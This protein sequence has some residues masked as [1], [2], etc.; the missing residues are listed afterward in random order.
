VSLAEYFE[1]KCLKKLEENTQLLLVKLSDPL[2]FIKTSVSGSL[3]TAAKG[4]IGPL[5]TLGLDYLK[6]HSDEIALG[7]L[8]A[9]G[10]LNKVKGALDLALNLT[11]TLLALH[12]D[13]VFLFM[14]KVA[15]S[16]VK[17]LAAKRALLAEIN[18]L[19]L[20]LLS[21]MA[22]YNEGDPAFEAYLKQLR[23]GLLHVA[24]AEVSVNNVRATLRAR[25]QFLAGQWKTVKD[26][27]HLADT[28]IRPLKDN[29][30][31]QATAKGLATNLGLEKLDEL[32]ALST[33]LSK[34]KT[35]KPDQAQ[36]I[37]N[38]LSIP[39]LSNQLLLKVRDYMSHTETANTLI[40]S[41]LFG[42]TEIES[43]MP[44]A[45]KIY[46]LGL[47]ETVRTKLHDLT[48]SMT[49]TLSRKGA[50]PQPLVVSVTA[51]KWI[52]DLH[53]IIQFVQTVPEDALATAT[54][55]NQIVE[56]YKALVSRMGKIN[57]YTG[58]RGVVIGKAGSEELGSLES[59][60]FTLMVEANVGLV[61]KT[62]REEAISLGKAIYQRNLTALR[63]D[64]DV[65][66]ILTA[67][68][69]TPIPAEEE[70]KK[71]FDMLQSALKMLGL[72]KA[73]D[74]L[75]KGKIAKFFSLNSK[76]ATYAGAALSA[77]A[78]LK[79][80]FKNL[81]D[82][83]ALD[84]VQDEVQK[85]EDLLNINISFDF[86]LAILKNL[87]DCLNFQDLAKLFSAKEIFCGIANSIASGTTLTKLQDFVSTL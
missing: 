60:L 33:K 76:D 41:W 45:L 73:A 79:E 55:N 70:L 83:Q 11:A 13:L 59:Q 26:E 18:E 37:S 40:E 9:T 32:G 35:I 75:N 51:Y 86:D 3:V 77:I 31:L 23:Q 87:L 61:G 53:L 85:D 24:K 71:L 4:G 63:R 72:D 52:L 8:K 78:L 50:G 7:A 34:G 15:E 54:L 65:E 38:I 64:H 49:T 58:G 5:A 43:A 25:D 21:A 1:K 19:L 48:Q 36:Q 46:T 69:K 42:V 22:S 84:K 74:Y 30:Y 27:L 16:A 10:T 62:I 81:E 12:N 39:A 20:R 6:K 68:I 82:Q 67:W 57:T 56:I 17:E 28:L 2:S 47:L 80:C 44:A 66:A 29:P 14:K